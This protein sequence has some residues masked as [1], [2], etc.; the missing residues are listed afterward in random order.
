MRAC[1]LQA[2]AD[3]LDGFAGV[4]E[5]EGFE[6]AHGHPHASTV[7]VE[8][9]NVLLPVDDVQLALGVDLANVASEEEPILQSGSGVRQSDLRNKAA[10][11]VEEL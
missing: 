2:D 10:G 11:P 7:D 3:L 8:I 9:D 5:V 6:E 1:V 4:G